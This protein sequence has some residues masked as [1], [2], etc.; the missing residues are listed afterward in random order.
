MSFIAIKRYTWQALSCTDI[1]QH[2]T[3]TMNDLADGFSP[4]LSHI[5]TILLYA[6]ITFTSLLLISISCAQ[7]ETSFKHVLMLSCRCWQ[8]QV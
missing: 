2:V 5:A 7:R 3:Q 8:S 4:D 6:S 1:Y